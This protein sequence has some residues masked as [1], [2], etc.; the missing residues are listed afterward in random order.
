MP[1]D[2]YRGRVTLAVAGRRVEVEADLRGGVEPISGQYQWYG[3]LAAAEAVREL[4]A[5]HARGVT[6]T[7]P[8]GSVTTTLADV[9]PWGRY[10]VGGVG[11]PPFPV[12][13]E[14]PA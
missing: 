1:D 12:L 7:T 8:H 13:T 3:R 4:A 2:G 9:D 10:R 5:A 14:P 11:S 6:L